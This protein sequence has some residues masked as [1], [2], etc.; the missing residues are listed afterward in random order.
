M[1]MKNLVITHH[2]DTLHYATIREVDINPTF[3]YLN[4]GPLCP[5]VTDNTHSLIMR[6]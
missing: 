5:F 2:Q 1:T 4:L 6:Q 3:A